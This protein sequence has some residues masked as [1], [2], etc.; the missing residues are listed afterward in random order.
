[1]AT[2]D[3]RQRCKRRP[4]RGGSAA[5]ARPGAEQ[6]VSAEASAPSAGKSAFVTRAA[7]RALARRSTRIEEALRF[8][9]AFERLVM[10]TSTRLLSVELARIDPTIDEALEQIGSFMQ[11]DR[12]YLFQLSADGTTM[13]NTHE[14]CQRGITHE[15]DAL[16]HVALDSAFPYFARHVRAGLVF[17][18]PHVAALPAEAA[19]EKAEFER[20]SIQSLICVPMVWL[21]KVTGFL[22]FD[23]VRQRQT[24]SE[25]AIDLLRIC[26]EIFASTLG[27]QEA[28]ASLR[29]SEA[30]FRS[31]AERSPNMIFINQARRVVYAN[32]R[33]LEVMGYSRDTLCAS[34][35]DFMQLIVPESRAAVGAA[36]A[37]HAQGEDV[38]PYEYALVTADARRLD[39]IISTKLIT[40]GGSHAI[41]GIITDITERKRY[42]AELLRTQKLESVGVLAGGI[43][44]DFNN[45][46]TA[47]LGNI[48]LARHCA[49]NPGGAAAWLHEAEKAA[50][51]ARDLTVQLLTFSR[52][53][54]PVR[55][56]LCLLGLVRDAVSLALSGTHIRSELQLGDG[57]WPVE[58][59]EGQL[60][61]VLHNL[62]I[63]AVQAMPTG[64]AVTVS[65]RNVALATDN[66]FA[67]PA[68]RY[69]AIA[70]RDEGTGIAAAHLPRIFDPYFTTKQK[71][72]G[73][74]LAIVYSIVRGHGG[75]IGVESALG[76]G[77]TFTVH[78]PAAP[79]NTLATA[80]QA[81]SSG[82]RGGH[83]RV[84]VMD[85]EEAVRR[86]VVAILSELGYDVEATAD[87]QT[88][89]EAYERAR[90]QGRPFGAVLL[91]LTVPG[92]MGGLAAVAVLRR[93]DPAVRAIVSSGYHDDP[94]MAGYR[95][96]GFV[97]VVAKP[98]D[99]PALAAVLARVVVDSV[100]TV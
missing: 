95:E 92:A 100:A 53:G 57:L 94:V 67:L 51:R 56:A 77:S 5:S 78:L 93:L 39:A 9:I 47:I 29:E 18:V 66:H 34:T 12:S 25:D 64:K 19:L 89:I 26:G 36:F 46:L 90:A 65:A 80:A 84:L 15:M 72:S 42:E 79:A 28:E 98:Y 61:Q 83:G 49:A 54:A 62:L 50:L 85:D 7:Y 20:Q 97:D 45:L 75:H 30:M 70:V 82:P 59:D 40:Y 13:S 73:L 44:H 76:V 35:F 4:K 86:V 3:S 69:L 32:D 21:G 31:L 71:G 33:C 96:H 38:P 22:G 1:M 74:G 41:R 11:V 48:S 17:H 6:A 8:R 91:D 81:S 60:A 37:R 58:A 43:A 52:G 88:A 87:G 23:R 99:A 27:R 14:W 63:N 2:R 68:G 10:A 24:W 16:Q 55:R